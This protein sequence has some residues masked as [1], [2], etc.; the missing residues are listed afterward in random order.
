MSGYWGITYEED[1]I[2]QKSGA[3]ETSTGWMSRGPWRV[4]GE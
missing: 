1:V 4:E 2:E 3:V